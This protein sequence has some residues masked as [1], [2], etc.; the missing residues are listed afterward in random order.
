MTTVSIS[1]TLKADK[2]VIKTS[3]KLKNDTE[4]SDST[5]I[6]FDSFFETVVKCICQNCASAK[7]DFA[8]WLRIP[9]CKLHGLMLWNP[10]EN[11][12]EQGS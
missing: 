5:S 12:K 2:A 3:L 1:Q 9:N 11:A 8:G 6:S 10:E 7:S 4:K